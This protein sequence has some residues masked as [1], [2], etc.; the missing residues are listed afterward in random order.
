MAAS[1]ERL[2]STRT[3]NGLLVIVVLIGIYLVLNFVIGRIIGGFL[4][5]YVL[6]SLLWGILALAIYYLLPRGRPEARLRHQKMLNWAAFLSALALIVAVYGVGLLQGY[7]KSPYDQ[8]FRGVIINI[9]Y[10]GSML[11]G[12]EL[13]RA[14]LINFLFKKK[15]GVGIVIMGLLFSFFAFSPRRLLSFETTLDG[16]EFTGGTFL[17]ALSENLLASYLAFLGGALPAIIY[18]G[19]LLACRW[20][21]PIL[22]NLN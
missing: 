7:S 8:S 2:L 3:K 15:P 4:G 18:R 22:P 13:S 17:P 10:L 6:P 1:F 9:F 19:T 21:V 16:A 12:M 20:F 14:W 5:S 11:A